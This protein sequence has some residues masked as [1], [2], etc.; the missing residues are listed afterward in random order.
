MSLTLTYRA[1]GTVSD[2]SVSTSSRDRNVDR[3]AAN[4]AKRIK[5]CPGSAGTGVLPLELLQ[6]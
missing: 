2:A 1:D 5:L 4:W 3:A 6:Q